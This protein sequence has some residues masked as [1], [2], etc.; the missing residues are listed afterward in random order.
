VAMLIMTVGLLG[1]LQSVNLAYEHSQRNRLRE[2]AM[3]LGEEQM[4]LM[5]NRPTPGVSYPYRATIIRNVGGID[6]PFHVT[7]DSQSMGD[8]RRLKVSVAW[9]FKNHTTTHAIYTLKS[10]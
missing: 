9:S 8:T 10:L 6:K 7:L 2:L 4:N 1:L 5:R 3:L